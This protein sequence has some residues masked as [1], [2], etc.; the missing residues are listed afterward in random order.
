MVGYI[1]D[2]LDCL[3]HER[4]GYETLDSKEYDRVIQWI[5][6]EHNGHGIRF[7]EV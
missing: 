7:R 5:I 6:K 4:L 2:C 1:V 3:H